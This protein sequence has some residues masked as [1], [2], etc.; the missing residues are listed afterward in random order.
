MSTL[1]KQYFIKLDTKLSTS[2]DIPQF[3]ISDCDT[4]DMLI[5]ITNENTLVNLTDVI[6]L[7]V[8]ISPNGSTQA[9]FLEVKKAEEGLIYCDLKES[10]KNIQGPWKARIMCIYQDEKIVTSTFSYNVIADE[11]V[12]LNEKVLSDD[13]Y[14]ILT[15]L[16]SRLS[17]IELSEKQRQTN[18]TSRIEAEKQREIVKQQL[19]DQINKLIADTEIK[20]DNYK[21]AKDLEIDQDLEL[22]KNLKDIQINTDL[23]S[24]KTSTTKNIE[25]YKST[26]DTQ[27]NQSLSTYE[28]TINTL[29]EDF[30]EAVSNVTNGNEN[31]T[32]SEIVL[33]RKGEISLRNKIDKIDEQFITIENNVEKI[34]TNQIPNEYLQTSIDN[35]VA[36]NSGGLASKTDVETLKARQVIEFTPVNELPSD[37]SWHEK[38]YMYDSTGNIVSSAY[39]TYTQALNTKLPVKPG[40]TY[41]FN[42]FQGNLFL[43]DS[44]GKNGKQYSNTSS[45]P[46][47]ITIPSGYYYIGLNVDTSSMGLERLIYFNR[48][49][50]NSDEEK[51]SYF[52]MPKLIIDK[53]Q[54]GDLVGKKIVN[55]GDSIF[56]NTRPPYDIS[57]KLSELTGA[58]VYNCGFGGTNAGRHSSTVFDAFSLYRL[59]DAITT[60][61]WTLQD[62]NVNGSGTL[63]YYSETLSLLKSLDFNDIDVITIAHG[64]NDFGNGLQ[65]SGYKNTDISNRFKYYDGALS[66]A[67]ETLLATFPHLKVFI[68]TPHYRI[69]LG[70]DNSFVED[71]NTWE[72]ESWVGTGGNH[73]LIDFVN[74]CKQVGK[75]CQIPVIDNYFDLGINKFNRTNYFPSNDGTH[76]NQNGRNL[77]AEHIAYKL[78]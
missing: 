19:I 17:I 76:H 44:T 55:L 40:Y 11:F 25:D 58:T 46:Y 5:R 75:D 20:I 66:Y 22:Y 35:Y 29:K 57:T 9:D 53:K 43:Y 71:S 74:A 51:T 61:N 47:K 37:L 62:S 31:A 72:I 2:N 49:T 65:P 36:N 64:T 8:A 70:A 7:M 32:N 18:E 33:A 39:A 50:A 21:T 15:D 48:L 68:V 10:F 56:G 77:I 45:L 23:E 27:I 34:A 16:I 4:S 73:T 24:Y 14:P 1:D 60:K 54:T 6:V 26:K 30:N 12:T 67:I 69:K 78:W 63:N 52:T 38:G 42:R 28:N 59:A 3:S 41:E 13:R